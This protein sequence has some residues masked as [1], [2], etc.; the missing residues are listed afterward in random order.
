MRFFVPGH[1]AVQ[2][3]VRSTSR[4]VLDIP[5][6][7]PPVE[8]PRSASSS[9]HAPMGTSG[10]YGYASSPV[11]HALSANPH[12]APEH[13]LLPP[14]LQRL[15]VQTYLLFDVPESSDAAARFSKI[16]FIAI[17]LS[18]LSFILE[19]EE[20][21]DAAKD[22]WKFAEV[23]F[24]LLFTVEYFIRLLVC[25]V[26]GDTTMMK[27]VRTR[28]NIFDLLAI[29]P[30]YFEMVVKGNSSKGLRVLRAV[31]LT[32]LLRLLR[33][34]K[35]FAGMRVMIDALVSSSQA[36]MV[37][38]FLFVVSAVLYSSALYFFER[39][40]CPS[41]APEKLAEYESACANSGDGFLYYPDRVELCCDQ[42]ASP[43]NALDF[44]SIPRALWWCA[45]TM[46][47]VG[48]GDIY[49]RTLLGRLVA[50]VTM[51]SGILVIALPV[52]IVGSR[53]QEVY[54]DMEVA[55]RQKADGR[56]DEVSATR[57]QLENEALLYEK[58]ADHPALRDLARRVLRRIARLSNAVKE[59]RRYK[60]TGGKV[61]SAETAAAKDMLDH[62]HKLEGLNPRVTKHARRLAELVELSL[63]HEEVLSLLEAREQYLQ[64]CVHHQY[65]DV[66]K[67]LDLTYFPWPQK[68]NKDVSIAP[69]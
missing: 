27:F 49:P 14:C 50:W 56:T 63:Q 64:A 7:E 26:L 6:S 20:G 4:Y 69:G 15:R 17:L 31:R 61:V 32:R 12:Y 19:A 36:L 10:P 18:I 47:T 51:L 66:L 46:T 16:M 45:V 38:A 5:N 3:I 65:E 29:S 53:F 42:G 24:T 43:P 54:N 1:A 67:L 21:L 58:I 28:G 35:N 59:E 39:M 44:P 22:V 2:R 55:K 62:L 52:A 9:G 60:D 48:F 23:F 8:S 68:T 40:G 13:R 30:W 57:R 41:I 34:G 33:G 25:D 11:A 37:L